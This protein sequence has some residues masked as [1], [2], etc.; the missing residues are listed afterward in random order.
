MFSINPVDFH[1][2][3]ALN[4]KHGYYRRFDSQ[5]PRMWSQVVKSEETPKPFKLKSKVCD[6]LITSYATC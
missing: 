5:S 6:F 3:C 4:V 2:F 1:V